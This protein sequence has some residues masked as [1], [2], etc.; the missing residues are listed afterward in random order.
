MRA[1]LLPLLLASSFALAS[2]GG[3]GGGQIT[4]VSGPSGSGQTGDVDICAEFDDSEGPSD[5]LI[6]A[7]PKELRGAATS[8]EDVGQAFDAVG[9]ND[10]LSADELLTV[11]TKDGLGD[12]LRALGQYAEDEC[13]TTQ[14][15][16]V[17]LQVADMAD[18]ASADKVDEYCDALDTRF[19]KGDEGPDTLDSLVDIAPPSHADALRRLAEVDPAATS[20]A[21]SEALFGPI[22]GLGVYTESVCGIEGSLSQM[23]VGLVFMGMDDGSGSDEPIPGVDPTQVPTASADAA[24]AA[25][26]ADSGVTFVVTDADLEDDGEYLASVVVPT[27]WER[28]TNFN[29]EFSPSDGGIFTS[30][31][32]GAGCDGTC[33]ATDWAARLREDMGAVTSFTS[34]HAD[35]AESAIEG[36]SGLVLTS[37]ADAAALVLRWDD[38]ADKYF[39]CSVSLEDEYV[40]LLSAFVQ[41]C[42]ASRPAWFP[43]G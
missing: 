7:L 11:L 42:V 25:L 4:K 32:F 18:I 27:G 21:D 24:N 6:A 33:A 29:V 26:P 39:S 43:V 1:R 30:I 35:A 10:E 13:G 19:V 2:C 34:S 40:G 28:E 5:E 14:G 31:E 15:S 12:E 36:S 20:S 38:R 3:G 17:V 41:A 22:V 9:G 8:M 37:A 16:T 23:L